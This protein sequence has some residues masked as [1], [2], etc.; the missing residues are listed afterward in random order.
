MARIHVPTDQQ[1]DPLG[2]TLGHYAPEIGAAGGGYAKAVYQSSRLPLRVM[3][4]ARFRIAQ[5]NGCMVCQGFRA[6][7]HLDGYLDSVG[8]DSSQSVVARGGAKPDEAFYGAIADWRNSDVF[9]ARE[10]IAIEFAE[11]MSE[12]P[13]GFEEDEPFWT[14]LH[15]QYSDAEIVDL[16]LCCGAWIALGRVTHILQLDTVCMEDTLAA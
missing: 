3:E 10:R 15:G 11:R 14:R 13:R 5:I 6:A 7:Q 1:H 2:Y 16:T 12:D 8:G 4:A 9:D